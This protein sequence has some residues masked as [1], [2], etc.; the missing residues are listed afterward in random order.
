MRH[1]W[2]RANIEFKRLSQ[3]TSGDII[4]LMNDPLV[5]RHMPLMLDHF[6]EVYCRAFVDDKERLWMKHGYGPWAILID[7]VFAGWGGVQPESGEAD[8]ALV[9]KPAYWG[10]GGQLI[11]VILGRAFRELGLDTVTTLLPPTRIR[12]RGLTRLG[13]IPAGTLDVGG[14]MFV[15]Y[16]LNRSDASFLF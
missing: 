7:G 8:I 2:N 9:L 4:S 14:Q 3:V 6:D 12:V 1:S 13:F 11:R 15:R 5:R 10:A 16:R